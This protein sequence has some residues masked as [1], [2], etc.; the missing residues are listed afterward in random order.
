M[1][2]FLEKVTA[3]SILILAWLH[4][5]GP[6]G[7]ISSSL[8]IRSSAILG[9]SID[10]EP[11][12]TSNTAKL[13]FFAGILLVFAV[14]IAGAYFGG[15]MQKDAELQ[16]SN[17]RIAGVEKEL[18][19]A[20]SINLMLHANDRLYRAIVEMDNRNFGSS[21][22]Y[23]REAESLLRRVAPGE[24]G[25]D[26]SKLQ[27]LQSAIEETRIIVAEDFSNQRARLLSLVQELGS[28]IPQP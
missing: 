6:T 27:G 24:L 25:L 15:V 8:W 26:E 7:T 16:K 9:S 28:L 12:L 10:L 23:V 4:Y 21:N 14:L 1:A 17:A 5:G 20:G 3:L 18:S 11:V 22:A 2:G 13:K 19:K